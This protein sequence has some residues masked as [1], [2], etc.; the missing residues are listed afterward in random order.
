[1]NK[2]NWLGGL[3][4]EFEGKPLQKTGMLSREQVLA[5]FDKSSSSFANPEFKSLLRVGYERGQNVQDLVNEM[6]FQIF[7]AMGVQGDF[8][9]GCLSKIRM[10]YSQDAELLKMFYT[11]VNSEEMLLDEVELPSDAYKA[12]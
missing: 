6:Q 7:Q 10:V 5:F 2:M 4:N 9:I 3:L 1:M 11:F 8:G 12:K